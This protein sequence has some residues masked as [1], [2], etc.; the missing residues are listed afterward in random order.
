MVKNK[1]VAIGT[2][3]AET[4]RS[5]DET[6]ALV[7]WFLHEGQHLIPDDPF[8]LTKLI[9]VSNPARFKEHL[10]FTISRGPDG[11]NWNHGHLRDNLH[12][13]YDLSLVQNPESKKMDEENGYRN[14][15][16][17]RSFHRC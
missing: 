5:I 6:A 17:K 9:T 8:Q 10:L 4:S 2:A 3:W 1:N 11:L 13:L 15:D 7:G 12:I 16:W 14:T